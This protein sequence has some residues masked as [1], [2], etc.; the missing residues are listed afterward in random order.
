MGR[1]SRETESITS[2]TWAI[3]STKRLSIGPSGW[4]S[5]GRSESESSDLISKLLARVH[6][7]EVR[8]SIP[9]HT[10]HLLPVENV[11]SFSVFG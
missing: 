6:I 2:F 3:L 8:S 11:V 7:H 5:S 4:G 10:Q 1:H 9:L